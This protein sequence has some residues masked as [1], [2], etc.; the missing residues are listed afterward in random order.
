MC[1]KAGSG[2]GIQMSMMLPLTHSAG[3]TRRMWSP[4]S[5]VAAMACLVL[6]AAAVTAQAEDG[7]DL[8]LRSRTHLQHRHPRHVLTGRDL[9]TK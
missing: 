4:R 8:W 6:L 9:E 3:E 5:L 1:M 7:Y 2:E